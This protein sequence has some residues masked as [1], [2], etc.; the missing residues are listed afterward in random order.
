MDREKVIVFNGRDVYE[1]G[2]P[3][4]FQ[5][6]RIKN[7]NDSQIKEMYSATL[8]Y[9]KVLKEVQKINSH[10]IEIAKSPEYLAKAERG[11]YI[12]EQ[13]LEDINLKKNFKDK[14]KKLNE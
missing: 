7:L 4:F 8:A 5:D 10:I 9:V 12:M 3:Y 1:I 11:L 6:R 2:A 13:M 14:L